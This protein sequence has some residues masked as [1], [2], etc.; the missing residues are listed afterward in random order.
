MAFSQ[1][2]GTPLVA[3]LSISPVSADVS[4]PRGPRN[5]GQSSALHGDSA[6]QQIR[7]ASRTDFIAALCEEV[8]KAASCTTFD[9]KEFDHRRHITATWWEY[10]AGLDSHTLKTALLLFACMHVS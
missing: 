5:R 6:A 9:N 10:A 2:T 7:K 4:S 3:N 1:T 8:E